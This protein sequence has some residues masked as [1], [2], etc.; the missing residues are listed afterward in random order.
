MN[1]DIVKGVA[2]GV[3]V[4]L[5]VPFVFP[6][7]GRAVRPAMQAVIRA[8]V[9]AWEKGREQVAEF[10]EYAEDVI[11]E[12]RTGHL[13]KGGGEGDGKEIPH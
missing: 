7:L 11:A 5:V 12:V 1:R 6:L 10:G 3:G 8:G 13:A 4:A 9:V 2:I